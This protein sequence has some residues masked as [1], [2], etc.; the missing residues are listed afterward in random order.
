MTASPGNNASQLVVRRAA[1]QPQDIPRKAASS[2]PFDRVYRFTRNTCWQV[3]HFLDIDPNSDHANTDLSEALVRSCDG[4][5]FP[6]CL[7]WARAS[8]IAI[9]K[10]T[11]CHWLIPCES[12]WLTGSLIAATRPRV[13]LSTVGIDECREG[14]RGT[15]A[16]RIRVSFPKNLGSLSRE[17]KS[18]SFKSASSASA[19]HRRGGCFVC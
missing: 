1:R 2:M 3:L 17:A 13:A 4:P 6:N 10:A 11:L 5:V 15:L 16:F 19:R 9:P 14:A 8:R 18:A 7:A 12:G